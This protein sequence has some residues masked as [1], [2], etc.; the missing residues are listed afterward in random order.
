MATGYRL[1]QYRRCRRAL[2]QRRGRAFN[3]PHVPTEVMLFVV[4]WRR[5]YK[6]G[7]RDLAGVFLTRGFTRTSALVRSEA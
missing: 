1:D 5:R 7:V 6:W 4:L 2:N 3:H